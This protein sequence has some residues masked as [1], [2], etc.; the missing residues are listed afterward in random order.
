MTGGEEEEEEEVPKAK[1]TSVTV[2]GDGTAQFG[3]CVVVYMWF[4]I[5]F[6]SWSLYPRADELLAS[7]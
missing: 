1:P 5:M 3:L 2:P 7:L 4:I 6:Y